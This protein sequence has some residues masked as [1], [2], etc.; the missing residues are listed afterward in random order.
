MGQRYNIYFAGEILDGR[1]SSTVRAAL[2]KLFNANEE[3]LERLFSG[4]AQLIK[5]ECDKATALKYK[6][7]MERA[8]ARPL[9][10]LAGEHAAPASPPPE[11][12]SRSAA[13]KIAALA[14]APDTLRYPGPGD[15]PDADP[16]PTAAPEPETVSLDLC[17]DGTEVLRPEERATPSRVDIDTSGLSLDAEA[18]RLS[19]EPPPP[20]TSP[21]TSHLSL[22]EAG[23]VLPTL[24]PERSPLNPDT[25]G[26]SL[27]P[28]G[29][30]FSDCARAGAAP[31]EPDLTGIE[32]APPHTEV[33]QEHERGKRPEGP[34]VATDH[35]QLAD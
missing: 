12:P 10:K 8:G 9:I 18:D 30:D 27:A 31:A 24:A 7:A 11:A 33:L 35:L 5:R 3:T 19:P 20:P 14:A 4:K 34:P 21:D 1:D 32:L 25:S 22:G 29:T 6:Q 2:S 15:T 16:E 23:E 13:E 26:I 28:E 17:P